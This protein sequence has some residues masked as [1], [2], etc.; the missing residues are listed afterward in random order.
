MARKLGVSLRGYTQWERGETYPRGKRLLQLLALC[1][2][3]QTR[4]SLF[5]LRPEALSP[6]RPRPMGRKPTSEQED[7]LRHYNDAVTGINLL[8]EAAD[9]GHE[10]AR[11]E[12]EYLADLI[13]KRAG[14][15]RRMKYLK[16]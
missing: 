15:W 10:G 1:P 8:Y 14:D 12:L 16:R 13:N 6:P 3:D 5:G 7:L 9:A 11:R 4:Q 2:D